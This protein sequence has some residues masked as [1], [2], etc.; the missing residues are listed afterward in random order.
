MQSRYE[1]IE[2]DVISS[3]QMFG[4]PALCVILFISG[5]FGTCPSCDV[6]NCRLPDCRCTD[7]RNEIHPANMADKPQVKKYIK[8]SLQMPI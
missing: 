5:A 1:I 3:F 8:V 4:F 2:K 7:T 6:E